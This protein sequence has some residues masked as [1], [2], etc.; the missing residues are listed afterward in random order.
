VVVACEHPVAG[1]GPGREVVGVDSHGA[2]D[3]SRPSL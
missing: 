3:G 1:V 2:D